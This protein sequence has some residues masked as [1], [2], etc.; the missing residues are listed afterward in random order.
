MLLAHDNHHH[1]PPDDQ[2]DWNYST[3]RCKLMEGTI[4]DRKLTHDHWIEDHL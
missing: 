4:E 3:G 2:F 1:H